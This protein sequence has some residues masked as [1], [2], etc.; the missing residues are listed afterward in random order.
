M[1]TPYRPHPPY[2]AR[3]PWMNDSAKPGH[4]IP[5]QELH[6]FHLQ[7]FQVLTLELVPAP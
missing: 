3:S 7:P 6:L 4:T 1:S 5:A 2:V